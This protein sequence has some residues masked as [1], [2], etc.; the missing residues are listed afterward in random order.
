MID[1]L[2]GLDPALTPSTAAVKALVSTLRSTRIAYLNERPDIQTAISRVVIC[3]TPAGAALVH[4]WLDEIRKCKAQLKSVAFVEIADVDS[5][6]SWLLDERG[7]LDLPESPLLAARIA[8]EDVPA[9]IDFAL[10]LLHDND[11]ASHPPTV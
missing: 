10:A 5:P 9:A 3:A 4:T 2:L 8:A 6:D 1:T 7:W 11:P